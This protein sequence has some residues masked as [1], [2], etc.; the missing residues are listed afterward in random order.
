M[1]I[2]SGL[3]PDCIVPVSDQWLRNFI[4][5]MDLTKCRKPSKQSLRRY[6]ALLDL[7]IM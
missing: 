6:I 3:N 5:K 1:T 4:T 2:E 7:K